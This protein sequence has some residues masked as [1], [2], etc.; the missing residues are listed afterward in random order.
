MEDP[1]LEP[2][3]Q[4]QAQPEAHQPADQIIAA[5]LIILLQEMYDAQQTLV[6]TLSDAERLAPGTFDRWSVKDT[7]AHIAAWID[8]MNLRL[9]LSARGEPQPVYKNVNKVNEEFYRV[10]HKLSWSAVL[11]ASR[12]AYNGL[13]ERIRE[14][15][16][17]DLTDLVRYD[18]L[19]GE[20]LWRRIMGTAYVHPLIH[21]T[22]YYNQRGQQTLGLEIQEQASQKLLALDDSPD[23]HSQIFYNLAC[24]YSLSG[25]KA[26]AIR[27][28]RQALQTDTGLL[29]WSKQ[30]PDFNPIRDD[31]EFQSI[32]AELGSE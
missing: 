3:T 24:L 9:D 11:E 14:L 32:Y 13:V 2:T 10:R 17:A 8:V 22:Y 15:N 23:W 18:W 29:D 19:E 30:D 12:K 20:P 27:R 28:L 31:P 16:E 6:L 26:T 5:G 7:L 21:L 4:I 1:I 25:D